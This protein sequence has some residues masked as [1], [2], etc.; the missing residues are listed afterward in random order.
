MKISS[1]FQ[2]NH[3]CVRNSTCFLMGPFKQM[4]NMFAETRIFATVIVM[5]SFV[6]TLV[7][8]IVVCET[9]SHYASFEVEAEA[10]EF[11]ISDIQFSVAQSWTRAA[12]HNN[13][14]FGYDLV[15]FVVH[16][17]CT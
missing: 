14:I 12:L 8:A 5:I 15:F 13:S 4:K 1:T 6:M 10:I 17:V 11:N 2:L 16:T 3:F 7:A 9:P